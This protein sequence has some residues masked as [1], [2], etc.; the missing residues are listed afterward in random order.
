MITTIKIIDML[1]YLK[2]KITNLA[3]YL[4]G[5]DEQLKNAQ[6][7]AERVEILK[8]IV[9]AQRQQMKELVKENE[10]L[11]KQLKESQKKIDLNKLEQRE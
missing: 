10:E 11:K 1:Q 9:E 6:D 4:L 2:N 3:S 8:Q 5:L 7:D